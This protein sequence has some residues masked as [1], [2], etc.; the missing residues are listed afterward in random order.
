MY[1]IVPPTVGFVAFSGPL[2]SISI[3][4]PK[5]RTT[6]RPCLSTSTLPGLRSRWRLPAELGLEVVAD[7]G[8]DAVEDLQRDDVVALAAERLD[9]RAERAG[10]ALAADFKPLPGG[11]RGVAAGLVA[12]GRRH[13]EPSACETSPRAP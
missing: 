11:Q 10:A 3:A 2:G 7:R 1:A 4:S 9:D 13:E 8:L 5:S 12:R 6:T